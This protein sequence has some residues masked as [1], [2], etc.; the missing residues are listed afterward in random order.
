[1]S[2]R[3]RHEDGCPLRVDSGGALD[4]QV[5]AGSGGFQLNSPRSI[6]YDSD[7]PVAACRERQLS[8]AAATRFAWRVVSRDGS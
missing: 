8:G 5:L 1:V 6:G 2:A 7:R 4:W 3:A